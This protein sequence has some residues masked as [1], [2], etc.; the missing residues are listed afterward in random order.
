MNLHPGKLY[1]VNFNLK[2]ANDITNVYNIGEAILKCAFGMKDFGIYFT[3]NLNFNLH[4]SKIVRKC[5]QI[6]GF[7]K[8]VTRDFTNPKTL[9]TLITP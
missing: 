1:Y 6:L 8:R 3:P 4:I 9:H 7:M 5:L 2:R